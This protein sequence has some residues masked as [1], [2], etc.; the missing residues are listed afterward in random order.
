MNAD[1]EIDA[2]K[3]KNFSIKLQNELDYLKTGEK[4]FGLS[5]SEIN[6]RIELLESILNNKVCIRKETLAEQKEN[7]FKKFDEG[8][9]KKPWNKLTTF[10]KTIKIKEYVKDNYG[11]G[12]MQNE[13]VI[14]LATH[15]NDGKINTKKFVV[16]DPNA[17]KILSLSCLEVD[18]NKNNYKIN[19]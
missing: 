1:G 7:M 6:D 17:E 16:Y 10:H 12:D 9:Y 5:D 18:I 4:T 11:D 19:F 14:K 3:N 8:A 2:I 13:I 15:I